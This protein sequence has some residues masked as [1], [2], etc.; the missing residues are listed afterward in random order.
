MAHLAVKFK[1]MWEEVSSHFARAEAGIVVSGQGSADSGLLRRPFR[2]ILSRQMVQAPPCREFCAANVYS[3][4]DD[5]S[6]LEGN[7]AQT[8]ARIR[9]RQRGAHAAR[10][11]SLHDRTDTLVAFDM[12]KHKKTLGKSSKVVHSGAVGCPKT[13][14]AVSNAGVYHSSDDRTAGDTSRRVQRTSS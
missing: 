8:K 10:F 14:N 2:R 11:F 3:G 5:D 6:T 4:D 9:K 13:F 7:R 1:W 12:S